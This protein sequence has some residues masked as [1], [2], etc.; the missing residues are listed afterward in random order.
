[1]KEIS[2]VIT[3]DVTV[4]VPGSKSLTQR[5]LIAAAL[6]DGVSTLVGPLASEDT[7]YTSEALMQMGIKVERNTDIWTVYGNGG[8]I[9][10]P[11]KEIFLGN[12]GTATRFLT[13]VAALGKGEF[14]IDGEERM[15]ERPIGPLMEALQGWGVDI[16]SVQGTECPPL[17]LNSNGLAGGATL[18]PEGKSSQYLSSLLL[19]APYAAMP[20]TLAVK[21]D[22]L[23]KPYVAMTLSVMSDFGIDV[24]CNEE[25]TSFVIPQGKYRPMEYQI[26]GDASNA[27]Y[28][29]AA[30]AIT[31]GRVTV[32]NV[33]VPSLQGDSGLVPLLARMGCDVSCDG[34]GITLQ[35]RDRLEGIT[36][37]MGD[38]PDVVPTLAV[39]AA[40]AHGKT[41]IQNIAHLRIKECDRL[42]A[43]LTEL[44]KMGVK[45]EEGEDF[46]VIHG[47]GGESLHGAEIETYKDH[48]MA[49]S[50]A[51]AGLKIP[52]VKI[53]GEECVA[54]SFPDFWE[55]FA[56][57]G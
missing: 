8:V 39:V 32:S 34:G 14:R 44:S 1:M 20:A 57:L 17:Q 56:K 50:F 45:V 26:E 42:N 16:S 11:E 36:V 52:G 28:F 46:M 48:R 25:Y 29:W 18:L 53:T 37:D 27:S 2:P 55:R 41:V 30:A 15:H 5:A 6:A 7:S 4:A 13:S 12:N 33:P 38:M 9:A 21:G 3:V 23:S 54:K 10:T 51:V 47:D 35:G 40:F 49:M 31:G 19:V 43:T 22:V 24:E